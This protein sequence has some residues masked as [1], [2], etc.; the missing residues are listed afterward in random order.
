M[1]TKRSYQ[2]HWDK[3]DPATPALIEPLLDDMGLG[4][5]GGKDEL[6]ARE[7]T[8]KYMVELIKEEPGEY[9]MTIIE[10]EAS[11]FYEGYLRGIQTRNKA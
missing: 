10:G 5:D 4:E 3:D 7:A 11:S 8:R 2:L 6:E 1:T 9:T